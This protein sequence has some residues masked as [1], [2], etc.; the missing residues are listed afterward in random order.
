GADVADADVRRRTVTEIGVFD[1]ART[2]AGQ[3]GARRVDGKNRV[4]HQERI[5]TSA[6]N[7]GGICALVGSH[8]RVVEREIL[9]AGGTVC[10]AA[11]A[12]SDSG[13][14]ISA[15]VHVLQS[16]VASGTGRTGAKGDPPTTA[17]DGVGADLVVRVPIAVADE[18]HVAN[19]L[20]AAEAVCRHR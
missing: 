11:A 17:E 19:G 14:L 16:L 5:C 2:E 3:F 4:A 9:A 20:A 13:D 12:A 7:P 10:V 6:P 1:V 8:R 18:L 15:H